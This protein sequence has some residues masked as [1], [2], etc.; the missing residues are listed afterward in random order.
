MAAAAEA[1]E[2]GGAGGGAVARIFV[3]GISEGVAA[4][5]LEAMFASVGRVAGVEFVR[6]NGR[7]FAYVDFHCPSDKALTKLFSTYNGCKW[8]GG[9]LRLEKAKEHYLTRLK[10][11]WEQEA[12]AAAASQ[13]MPAS[14]DVESKKEKLEL[15]KAVLDSTKINI[16]FP[17]LRKVK[18]LPFKGTG[19]HKYSFRHIEVPSY[20]IH[21]CDCEEHC[22]PPEAANDEY[23]SV[24]NAAAYEKERSIMNSVMSKLFE[25][26]NEHCDSLEIH[27]HDVDF[28]AMEPS[29]TRNDLQMEE[30]EETSEVDSDGLQTEETEDP[31]E[32]ELDDLVLNIVTRKPKSSVAEL[33]REKH[34]ACKDSRFKKCQ[35]FEESSPR[36]KRQKSSDFS[37]TRNRKQYFPAISGAIQ[38]EQKSSGLSG[39]GTHEFSSKLDRDRSSASVQVVEALADSST[40]NGSGQNAVISEPKRGSLWT[41]KSAWRDLVGGIG[42]AS[43]SLSQ[44]LPNTNP[45]PPKLSNATEQSALGA[46]SK[47]KVKTSRTS[48]KPSEAAAHLLPEQKIPRSIAM[49]SSETTVGLGRYDTSERKENNKLEKER[50]VPKITIGEVCPFM[51]N[52]ESEKQWSKAKKV[53][54]G[55]IKKG[56]GSSGSNVGK[57]K[58]SARR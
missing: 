9:K 58:P 30:T 13:E 8:K 19:K 44:V 50:V 28:N 45:A 16:Y 5:E 11:E 48:L 51:R 57:G 54:T 33:N 1:E 39:K 53:L 20:P 18:A 15:N 22:G 10:R 14:G 35:Q 24:L 47:R 4:D 49:P 55:I 17:K 26:E 3:G 2:E 46:E 40:R 52:T 41:Q 12:E 34:A 31:S 25:K 6:T 38:N 23:A 27:N 43:F 7:S 56:N 29:N 42:S 37:E 21:F 36:K 32:E